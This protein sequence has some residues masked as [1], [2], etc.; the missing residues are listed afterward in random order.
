MV[1]ALLLIVSVCGCDK[2]EAAKPPPPEV[3]VARPV[4]KEVTTY[5]DFTGRT[6]A[7]ET[8]EVRARVKGFLQKVV[9]TE[10]D[11]VKKGD[12]LFVI[13]PA[14][15]EAARDRE[16]AELEAA[17]A[18]LKK[19]E[20]DLERMKYSAQKGIGSKQ[21]LTN[22]TAERDKAKA[23][24][25]SSKAELTEAELQLSYTQIKSAID[26]RVGR[27]LVKPGNLVGAGENTLLTTVVKMDPM[28]AYFDVSESVLLEVA[29]SRPK[30]ERR[31]PEQTV[32]LGLANHK[33]YPY[34]GKLDYVDNT[35]DP[36]TGTIR[37]RGVFPNDSNM[38][39]PGLFARIRLPDN[40]PNDAV[41]VDE[42]AIGS[43]LAGKYVLV[44][45]DQDIVEQRPIEM[46][47]LVDGMRVVK[48]GLK[49]DERYVVNG[50][51]HARPGLPVK[52]TMQKETPAEPKPEGNPEAAAKPDSE[53][54]PPSK[55]SAK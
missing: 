55:K 7:V 4:R 13:D 47:W 9:F 46:G 52:P 11:D 41:L 48:S 2:P 31:D 42:R 3:T 21:D 23:T 16:K 19:R 28:Y 34:K 51:Q 25:A 44:V 39:F 26:G 12:L 38:L 36:T 8:L 6:E 54:K 45:N 10:G 40:K 50:L 15:F 5:Y 35:L 32:F 17:Q 1:V 43:D 33:D 53:K 20:I 18:E 14:E 49:G 30:E 22:A 29:E 24:V 37:V 27:A